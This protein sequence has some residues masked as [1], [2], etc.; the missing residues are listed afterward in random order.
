MPLGACVISS[1]KLVVSG[2]LK[3]Y[4][5]TGHHVQ[6][7]P[8]S[9][10]DYNSAG[11]VDS[12][13]GGLLILGGGNLDNSSGSAITSSTYNPQMQWNA[14]F[15]FVGSQGA[16]S[17]L[18]LGTGAVNLGTAMRR[19]T[20]QNAAATLTVGG[21]ITNMGGLTKAGPGTLKLSGISTYS[22]TTMVSDGTLL[23][24]GSMGSGTVTVNPVGSLGGS[25]TLGG[26]VTLNGTISPGSSIGTLTSSNQ[27]WNGAGAYRFEVSSAVNSA[28]RDLLNIN[29]A[30][31]VQATAGN[32]FNLK[33]VSLANA[34]TPGLVPDFNAG[35][36]YTWT[37]AMASGGILNFDAAKVTVDTSAFANPLLGTFSVAVQGNSLVV[38]Y[39]PTVTPVVSG[40]QRNGSGF[41]FNFAG[42]EGQPWTILSSTNLLLPFGAWETNQSGFFDHTGTH[43]Y[44]NSVMSEPWRFY[45]VRSP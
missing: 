7:N 18:Y 9:Q 38:K 19:V 41:S 34:T 26:R 32:K 44:T 22:G 10:L 20:I 31:D 45:Q 21:A 30:L 40:A 17:D 28:A 15:T 27:T 6:V 13:A 2:T 33:L 1:G 35:S 25:G 24:N 4:G 29:G 36:N 11:A 37:V 12:G 5:G 3:A 43:S 23:V 39:T 8:G 14:D 42:P 16:N